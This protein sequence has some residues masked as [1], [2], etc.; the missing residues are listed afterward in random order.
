M[1]KPTPGFVC[2]RKGSEAATYVEGVAGS[3]SCPQGYT[4]IESSDSCK[5][6]AEAL[7]K[8]WQRQNVN[9]E[10]RPGGCF[11]QGGPVKYNTNA[12]RWLA[13]VAG[14]TAICK[15]AVTIKSLA[16]EDKKETWG[17]VEAAVKQQVPATADDAKAPAKVDIPATKKATAG[18]QDRVSLLQ[19][20]F[21][22][23][24]AWR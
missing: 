21:T 12:G 14:L 5:D 4:K 22:G 15:Q 13:K 18:D 23:L 16:Q 19:S 1:V 6:A 9:S 17:D 10:N 8:T 24:A 3:S 11:R 2:K 20:L 7:G